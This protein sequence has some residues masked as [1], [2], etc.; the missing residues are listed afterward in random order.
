MPVLI[1]SEKPGPHEGFSGKRAM[2]PSSS[3]T[4][5]PNSSGLSTD[6][7]PIVTAAPRSRCVA[8]IAPRAPPPRAAPARGRGGVAAGLRPAPRGGA[9]LPVRRE[10]RAQVDVAERVAGDDEDRLV[11]PPRR[12]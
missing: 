7:R 9:A 6:F 11:E 12:E 8:R 1:V 3:V 2:R 4:T 10:H 5:I